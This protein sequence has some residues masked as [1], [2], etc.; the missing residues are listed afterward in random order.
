MAT[1]IGEVLGVNIS[2]ASIAPVLLGVPGLLREPAERILPCQC[3]VLVF[4][5]DSLTQL[6]VRHP[7]HYPIKQLF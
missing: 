3:P 7:S 2:T 1:W 6:E 4:E 5:I